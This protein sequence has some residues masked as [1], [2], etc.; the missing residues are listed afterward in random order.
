MILSIVLFGMI[1]NVGA[2]N[3]WH[4]CDLGDTGGNSKGQI[5]VR[6][7]ENMTG[8]RACWFSNGNKYHTKDQSSVVLNSDE[9]GPKRVIT[10]KGEC[11]WDLMKAIAIRTAGCIETSKDQQSKIWTFANDNKAQSTATQFF[12]HRINDSLTSANKKNVKDV[13]IESG[14]GALQPG[15][16]RAELQVP[17]SFNP[18]GSFSVKIAEIN[19][20][21]DK[22]GVESLLYHAML[23]EKTNANHNNIIINYTEQDDSAKTAF[24][25]R[26]VITKQLPS[27]FSTR[28]LIQRGLGI[29]VVGLLALLAYF[30]LNQK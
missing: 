24:L 3:K 18:F 11:L 6:T 16:I 7:V 21:I 2:M 27:Y 13:T 29:S 26:D 12:T 19:L 30:K 5:S 22:K 28:L 15:H 10:I 14:E 17:Y 8:A 20:S 25:D 23:T 9:A 1:S 4:S